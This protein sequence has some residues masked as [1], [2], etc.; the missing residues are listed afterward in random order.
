MV[1]DEKKN[2][3]SRRGENSTEDMYNINNNSINNCE[4][5]NSKSHLTITVGILNL[6][7]I[8]LS[9]IGLLF[10]LFGYQEGKKR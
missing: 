9:T 7:L 4:K 10:I 3:N 5:E 8:T 2:N 6:I 1:D